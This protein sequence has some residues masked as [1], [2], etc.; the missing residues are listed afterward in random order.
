MGKPMLGSSLLGPGQA[1]LS[2]KNFGLT[3][4]QPNPYFIWANWAGPSGSAYFDSAICLIYWVDKR[5]IIKAQYWSEK[6]HVR[7]TCGRRRGR[8]NLAYTHIGN[9]HGKITFVELSTVK[10]SWNFVNRFEISGFSN[11]T[12]GWNDY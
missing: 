2:Q 10:S 7:T 3:L 4:Y 6:N 1:W 11:S 5:Q 8:V 12:Y 9:I